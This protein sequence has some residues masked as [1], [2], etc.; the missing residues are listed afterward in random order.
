[1]NKVEPRN[2]CQDNSLTSQPPQ[3]KE[4]QDF[5][6]R[7]MIKVFELVVRKKMPKDKIPF[8]LAWMD[9]ILE[10]HYKIQDFINS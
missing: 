2:C 1:M 7:E 3:W 5:L 9:N 6:Y 4:R 10:E 8:I